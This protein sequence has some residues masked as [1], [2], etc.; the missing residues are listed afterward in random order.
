MPSINWSLVPEYFHNYI[1]Q[2]PANSLEAA[3]ALHRTQL[4]SQLS[5]VPEAKW[6]YSYA[7]GKW[8]IKEVVQHI[9]DTER[10]FCYRALTIARKDTIALPGFDENAYTAVA[11]ANRRTKSSLLEELELVQRSTIALFD[12][13]S[14]EMLQ[15]TGI[16][17][18]YPLYVAGA[19]FIIVGHGLH[20]HRIFSERYLS[21][22][23]MQ[24]V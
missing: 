10:I 22:L 15:A 8:S 16:A 19:G 11:H 2:V 13:F 24:A 1:R 12:S 7:A 5:Q 4:L 23:E 3:F 18:N 20:H 21:A 17:S 9:I 6:E 14:E